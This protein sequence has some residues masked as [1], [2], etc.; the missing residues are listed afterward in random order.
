MPFNYFITL[1]LHV[2]RHCMLTAGLGLLL[3]ARPVHTVLTVN[4]IFC[5]AEIHD[6]RHDQTLEK[7]LES[8]AHKYF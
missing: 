6:L 4:D 1:L 7:I 3:F 5:I 2:M 8:K